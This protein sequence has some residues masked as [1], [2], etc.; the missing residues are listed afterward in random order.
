MS[1]STIPLARAVGVDTFGRACLR[2]RGD[3]QNTA[4]RPRAVVNTSW[5]RFS[6][7]RSRTRSIAAP[8]RT[9]ERI[10]TCSTISGSSGHSSMSTGWQY[11]ALVR[12]QVPQVRNTVPPDSG[13]RRR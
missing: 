1:S 3:C 12:G 5:E 7:P 2:V 11:S 8:R 13:R 10:A 6:R 4:S 9:Q